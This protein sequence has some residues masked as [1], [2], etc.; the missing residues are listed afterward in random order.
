MAW[1]DKYRTKFNP[2]GTSVTAE[3]LVTGIKSRFLIGIYQI[4]NIIKKRYNA[5]LK[6]L[7]RAVVQVDLIAAYGRCQIQRLIRRESAVAVG[8]GCRVLPLFESIN[9]APA[10]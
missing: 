3:D 7:C 5:L 1:N 2:G 6:G 8:D 4:G 10:R 9:V